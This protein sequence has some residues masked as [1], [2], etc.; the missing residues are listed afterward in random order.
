MDLTYVGEYT[1]VMVPY[2]GLDYVWARD[3]TLAV[4]EALG[5]ILLAQ[6][7]ESWEEAV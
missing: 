1:G 4:P 2:G 5:D 7:P 6:N 3:A